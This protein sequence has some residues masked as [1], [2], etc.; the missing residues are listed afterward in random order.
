MKRLYTLFLLAAMAMFC[1]A[2]PQPEPDPGP[3]P[4]PAPTSITVNPTSFDV[5]QAGATLSLAVKAPTRPSVT[6][7][8]AWIT[9]KDGTYNNYS[10]TFG[11]VVAANE[12]YEERSVTLTVTSGSLS[13]TVTL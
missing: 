7:L 13:A 5:A 12:S 8:P 4:D 3:T 6:G 10:V 9:F 11:L 2:C 1:T